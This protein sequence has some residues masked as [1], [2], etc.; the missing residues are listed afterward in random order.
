MSC[1]ITYFV[2]STFFSKGSVTILATFTGT[3]PVCDPHPLTAGGFELDRKDVG[4][5]IMTPDFVKE[6]GFHRCE[7]EVT[8]HQATGEVKYDYVK[9]ENHSPNAHGYLTTL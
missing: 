3:F 7:E 8:Q 4:L 6:A 9:C 1:G 2:D 5:V